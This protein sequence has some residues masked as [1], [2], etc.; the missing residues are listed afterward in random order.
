MIFYFS[1]TGNSWSAAE[2]LGRELGE[3]VISIT[4]A[5]R[6][7]DFTYHLSEGEKVG[8]VFP[9]FF[10]G[11]PTIVDQFVQLMKLECAKAPYIFSVITCGEMISGADKQFAKMLEKRDHFVN[12]TFPL[13]MPNNSVLW[14]ELPTP[15]EQVK[16]LADADESLKLIISMIAKGD[17][18][19]YSSTLGDRVKTSFMQSLYKHGRKTAKFYADGTC[20]GCG[21]C[22]RNCPC[23]AIK[24]TN[25]MPEW[26]AKRC[27]LC[28]G[29]INRCP[30]TAI[31]YGKATKNR[32]RYVNPILK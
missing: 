3:R 24:M 28:L 19:C 25:K 30:V 26:V 20:T 1:A 27:T 2:T 7:R 31:Q 17:T 32:R 14:Y 11:V 23:G 6:K 9:V 10:Y 29:C 8:F 5:M 16:G 22:E 4:E 15:E 21:E 18:G 13:I 12:C